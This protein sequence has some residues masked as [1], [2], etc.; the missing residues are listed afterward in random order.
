[1]RKLFLWLLIAPFLLLLLNCETGDKRVVARI[2]DE[3]ITVKE[4]R[5]KLQEE[6]RGKSLAELTME[7]KQKTLDNI[8]DVRR[9][10]MW[11]QQNNLDQNPAY[12]SELQIHQNRSVAIALYND[13][14]VNTLVPESLLK[15]YYDW[16]NQKVEA[17]VIHVGFKE[18]QVVKNDRSEEEA[19]KLIE[20]YREKLAASSDPQ[21]TAQELTDN[22]QVSV[23]LRPY[24]IGRFELEADKAVFTTPVGEVSEP[25]RSPN[26]GFM[27]FKILHKEPIDPTGTYEAAKAE[28]RQVL[29][30]QKRQEEKE[31]FDKY[32]DEFQQKFNAKTSDQ[33]MSRFLEILK[34]W[35]QRPEHDIS[36]FTDEQRAIVLG[37]VGDET[38][39]SGDFINFFKARLNNDYRKFNTVDDLK[40]SYVQ[41]QLNLMSWGMEGMKRGYQNKDDVEKDINTFR[42]NRLAQLF[43]ENI[44]GEGIEV[45]DAEIAGYYNEH[46]DKYTVQ[47]K[48]QVWQIPVKDES[49]ARE[50]IQKAKAGADF[51]KLSKQYS[52]V[53]QGR[54]ARFDLGY[55]TPQSQQFKEVV[56]KAFEVGANEI[57][58]PVMVDGTPCVIKTGQFQPEILKPLGDVRA[59][60][61]ATLVNEKKKEKREAL[62]EQLRKE[63][64]YR[65]NESIMRSVS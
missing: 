44:V 64:A 27:V 40:S 33:E 55:Q 56:E 32:S 62:I 22:K 6:Y 41:P 19:R 21:K 50:V 49:T 48:I 46:Q 13:I 57:G 29:R 53:K 16:K 15:Q 42:T 65:V 31:L 24:M 12:L 25:I 9:K 30:G 23:L 18:T 1:M 17:V 26:Y 45:S 2:G 37:K 54:L 58:G 39:T 36:D 8:L 20:E 52:A 61:H 5:E 51:E 3:K 60:I 4:F 34:E 59:S 47:E 10:V 11:A 35:G 14:V 63:Y 7:E 38:V 28:L 43:E